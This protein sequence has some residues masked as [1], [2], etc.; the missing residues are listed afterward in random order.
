VDELDI[1][2]SGDAI[3]IGFNVTYLIDALQNMTQEMVRIELSGRQQLGAGH[4]P[5]RQRVQ[6]RG[7]AHADLTPLRRLRRHPPGGASSGPAKPVPRW[8]GRRSLRTTRPQTRT[9]GFGAF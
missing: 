9:C 8:P 5:R 1:D 6:V 3:E 7:D 4:Q 2:Y